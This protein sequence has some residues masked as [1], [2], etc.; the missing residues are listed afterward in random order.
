MAL[1]GVMGGLNSEVTDTT[2]KVLLESAYFDPPTIRKTSKRTGLRSD[3][4]YR[5]ERGVDPNNTV[6][7]LDRAAYL[8]LELAGGKLSNQQ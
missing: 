7:A 6:N 2:S 1:G 5:F 3:S 4:S 8:I